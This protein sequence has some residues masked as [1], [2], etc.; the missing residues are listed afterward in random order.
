MA[1]KAAMFDFYAADGIIK[2]Y[3]DQQSLTDMM[4]GHSVTLNINR[5]EPINVT[6][7]LKLDGLTVFDELGVKRLDNVSF[8][9]N[10][11]EVLGVDEL[12][13]QLLLHGVFLRLSLIHI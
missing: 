2:L 10:A 1:V 5:P 7:R 13:E 9:V 12:E 6:P 4:V 8:T 3:A 11:G